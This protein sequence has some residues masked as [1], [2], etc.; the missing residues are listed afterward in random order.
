MRRWTRGLLRLAGV[1]ERVFPEA[2]PRSSGARLVVANHRSALDIPLLL[3]YFGGSFVSRGDLAEWP[4]LGVAARKAQTIF[5]GREDARKGGVIRAMREQFE[6]GRTVCIFPEGTT[7]AGD[8]V[9]PFHRG[10]FA[11]AAGLPVE[12]VPVGV[13]YPA[14]SEYVEDSF[15]AHIQ[16]VGARPRT[17]VVMQVGVP[18]LAEG[19]ST[20]MQQRYEAEVQ[21]LV[22]RARAEL[23]RTNAG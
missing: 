14:G 10:A 15:V 4:L 17:P 13:A 22:H 20:H 18:S 21:A 2:P 8:E 11:A 12:I 16:A 5:V 23:E 19:T 6:R 1:A 3:T 7:F 9:R